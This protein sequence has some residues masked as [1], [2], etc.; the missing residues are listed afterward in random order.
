MKRRYKNRMLFRFFPHRKMKLLL[1]IAF[2][3]VQFSHA[4]TLVSTMVGLEEKLYA[5]QTQ[6][7]AYYRNCDYTCLATASSTNADNECAIDACSS[8]FYRHS[9]EGVEKTQKFGYPTVCGKCDDQ[10][11]RFLDFKHSGVTNADIGY[12]TTNVA[13][14]RE[15]ACWTSQLD[16]DWIKNQ[17]D[18]S[19][20]WQ[21]FGTPLGLHRTYPGFAQETCSTYDP[22]IRSWYVAATTGP[23]DV[24]VIIDS[25]GSMSNANRM[26]L[27]RE[28]AASVVDT[29]TILDR[30]NVIEFNS[31]SRT[32]AGRSGLAR[33]TDENK[34]AA[35]KEIQNLEASGGT[36]MEEAFTHAFQ[37]LEQSITSE[38]TT[39]CHKVILFLTDGVPSDGKD[40]NELVEHVKTLNENFEAVVFTY[41]LGSGAAQSLPKNIA[42]AT[43]GIW[44]SVEDGETSLRTQMSYYYDYIAS[45]RD[46]ETNVVWVEPYID[47]FGSGRLTT[48]AL[49]VYDDQSDPPTLLGV[50]GM[51]ITV[52]EMEQ[53]EPNHEKFLDKFITRSSPR[54]P[55]LK[56]LSTCAMERLRKKNYAE[57]DPEFIGSS[58]SQ[59][60]TFDAT[61]TETVCP[62]EEASK[63]CD[64]V[65]RASDWCKPERTTFLSET[66]VETCEAFSDGT[67]RMTVGLIFILISLI[68]II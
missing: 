32:L 9:N 66:C 59:Q 50:L 16:Q 44:T 47:A 37:L 11:T 2:L 19:V 20:S 40:G 7:L 58:R 25:S 34:Q 56:S 60:P 18:P 24:I 14:R 22:R 41:S 4:N 39:G 15:L 51:D 61:C 1:L 23:K 28:A 46:T 45:L 6:L 49:A 33:A 29:L 55:T 53:L 8:S 17:A 62:D 13:T 26:A 68:L 5:L 38:A 3:I 36:Y 10:T 43:G 31:A 35:I 42:C 57:L 67:E 52:K 30:F 21:Y 65:V 27:A 63:A 48:A 12:K 54:C 64:S